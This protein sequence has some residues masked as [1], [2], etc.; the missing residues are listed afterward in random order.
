MDKA[1][2]QL[3]ADV[4]SALAQPGAFK[5]RILGSPR[6][7]SSELHSGELELGLNPEDWRS[8]FAGQLPTGAWMLRASLATRPGT[9]TLR[10]LAASLVPAASAPEVRESKPGSLRAR[11]GVAL[12]GAG[13]KPPTQVQSGFVGSA[14]LAVKPFATLGQA[15]VAIADALDGISGAQQADLLLLD[16]GEVSTQTGKLGQLGAVSPPDL[17]S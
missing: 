10:Q 3:F 12:K 4:L 9:V 11:S 6:A 17:W 16:Q 1:L 15:L 14:A 8:L 7:V 13:P 5:P 2:H